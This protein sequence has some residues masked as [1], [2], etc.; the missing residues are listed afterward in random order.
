MVLDMVVTDL[1]IRENPMVITLNMKKKMQEILLLILRLMVGMLSQRVLK[2]K[3][4]NPEPEKVEI[5][6]ITEITTII[7]TKKELM[8]KKDLIILVTKDLITKTDI[9]ENKTKIYLSNTFAKK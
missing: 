7:I 1:T 6:L 2:R 4:T 9:K 8:V 3:N 5:I